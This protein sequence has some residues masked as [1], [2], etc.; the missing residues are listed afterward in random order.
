[1]IFKYE[2]FS[3]LASKEQSFAASFS[4]VHAGKI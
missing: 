3:F 2:F 4:L 1:M